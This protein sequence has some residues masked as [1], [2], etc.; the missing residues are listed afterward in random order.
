MTG[1]EIRLIMYTA[2]KATSHKKDSGQVDE[3][4]R[5]LIVSKMCRDMNIGTS[6]LDR[7]TRWHLLT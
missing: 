6:I 4:G 3:K 2:I 1:D 5:A 7:V